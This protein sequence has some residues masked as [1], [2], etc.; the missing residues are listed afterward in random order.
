MFVSSDFKFRKSSDDE[1][2]LIIGGLGAGVREP[3]LG[4]G[5]DSGEV[6]LDLLAQ[7]LKHRDSAPLGPCHPFGKGIG[8]FIRTSLEGQTQIFLEEVGLVE[9]GIDF[10]KKVQLGLLIFRQMLRVF[11]QGISNV[12]YRLCVFLLRRL[13]LC[14]SARFAPGL[15]FVVPADLRPSLPAYLIQSVCGPGDHM[16]RVNVA[17]SFGAVF[18]HAR[19]NPP[20]SIR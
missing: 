3:E 8:D 9:F 10:G 5:N 1:F 7:F 15:I 16:E 20:G 17:L 18:L 13:T 14:G 19:G 11:E 4:S 6:A 2:D 12:F